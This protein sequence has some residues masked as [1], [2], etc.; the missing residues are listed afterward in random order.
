MNWESLKR[1][2]GE[3][4]PVAG[5][6][7][8]GPAG[9]AIGTLISGFLGVENTPDAVAEALKQ[10]PQAAIELRKFDHEYRGQLAEL[11]FK[12]LQEEMK[13]KQHARVTHKDHWMPSAITLVL[14]L[15]VTGIFCT[16]VW[17]P[18]SE[19]LTNVLY[20]MVGQVVG[21]FMTAIAYWLGTSRSSKEKDNRMVALR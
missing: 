20:L 13:D 8:G 11:T 4:A 15:M 14:A 1:M 10:N 17:V 2:V 16:L 21:A 7:L 5:S 18:I 3:Y 6:L 12:T 9:G 19:T